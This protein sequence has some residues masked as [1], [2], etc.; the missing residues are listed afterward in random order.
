MPA[1]LPLT[2]TTPIQYAK[3]VGEV[4]A[5]QFAALEIRTCGDLLFHLPRD[6]LVYADEAAV[7]AMRPGEVATV[8][9]R[10]LQT[11]M[12]R[13]IGRAPARLEAL[14]EDA[15]ENQP[16][17]HHDRCVLTWFNPYDLQKKI[18]PGTQLRATGKVTLFRNRAQITQPKIE[19][20]DGKD[21]A[22]LAP[23]S[24]HIEPV[25][26]ATMELTSAAIWKILKGMIDELLTEV[27]EWFTTDYLAQRQFMTRVQ[28][29][30][31]IHLPSSL[32]DANAAKRTLAYHEFFLHQTAFAIKRYHQRHGSP[33][34]PLRVDDAVDERIRKLLPF[35]LTA[36]Q[37]RVIEAI[38]KDLAATKPMNRLLQGDVGSG[39]T[40]VALYAMLAACATK[41]ETRN[42][43]SETRNEG[44][45]VEAGF[46]G[47][48]AA[49][50]A[51]TEIL[52]EQHFITLSKM[53]EGKKVKIALLTG[54]VTGV[55]RR[56]V[57]REIAEGKVGIVVGTHALLSEAVRFKSL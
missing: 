40:V 35:A 28:A 12:H 27:E 26:P 41:R 13:R 29:M 11:R 42:A 50:M 2:L 7:S 52:A 20:L 31:S 10:I 23:R 56:E 21:P 22:A 5:A 55:E 15:A 24:A 54:S 49:L 47:C 53:L 39:K 18:T 48:Q 3:G 14:L 46:N 8:R 4:R 17:G 30:R 19:I 38:R 34:I 36:A 32:L 37:N 33:A 57:L 9:G 43:K 45:V 16:Q 6:Y 51:P 25:Y 1:K 44:E